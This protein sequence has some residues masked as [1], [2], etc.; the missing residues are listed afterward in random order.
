MGSFETD[1]HSSVCICRSAECAEKLSDEPVT[2]D[3]RDVVSD[4]TDAS[5]NRH[6]CNICDCPRKEDVNVPNMSHIASE[7]PTCASVLSVLTELELARC[8]SIGGELAYS[9][10][11]L[12]AVDEKIG[13]VIESGCASADDLVSADVTEKAC[14][15]AL[16]ISLPCKVV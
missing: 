8:G 10:D 5:I 2:L 16:G 4:P 13:E 3:V 15:T 14:E 1:C 6:T 11:R 12:H 9:V 7:A